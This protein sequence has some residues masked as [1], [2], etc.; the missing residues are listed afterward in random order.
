MRKVIL[1]GNRL[2]RNYQQL[3]SEK[4]IKFNLFSNTTQLN[5]VI[6]RSNILLAFVSQAI[7]PIRT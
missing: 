5:K 7:K 2:E 6:L 4:S 3:L 1:S